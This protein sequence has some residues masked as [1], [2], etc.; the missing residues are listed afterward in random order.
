MDVGRGIDRLGHLTLGGLPAAAAA[1]AATDGA[2][3]L[4]T[5]FYVPDAPTPAAETDGPIG[6]VQLA[7]V[8]VALDKPV[9]IATDS[10]CADVVDAALGAAGLKQL[11]A[12]DIV[13]IDSGDA[14]ESVDAVR[15]LWQS[16]S[17]PV[18]EAVSIERCGPA[19]CGRPRNFRGVDIGPWTAPMHELFADPAWATT[20]IGDGG[21]ELGMGALPSADVEAALGEKAASVCT[22]AA[23]RLIIASVSN[24]GAL[25]LALELAVGRP[26]ALTALDAAPI[27][28]LL[29]A[30][31]EAGA[32]DGLD[33]KNQAT[34][35]G[36]PLARHQAM[37]QTLRELVVR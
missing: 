17:P 20:G 37:E 4:I 19:R 15:A 23:D 9:R 26:E 22:V 33:L 31:V 36:L 2:I 24:W 1:L 8:L 6:T 16:A 13:A 21:N 18:R 14:G 3:G 10:L 11:V 32:I 28:V 12:L 34:V 25:A 30:M 35:D 29:H 5:G 7:A 27:D